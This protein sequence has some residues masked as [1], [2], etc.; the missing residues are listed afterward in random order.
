MEITHWHASFLNQTTGKV[1]HLLIVERTGPAFTDLICFAAG[2]EGAEPLSQGT[3]DNSRQKADQWGK[4]WVESEGFTRTTDVQ[5][6]FEPLEHAV[7]LAKRLGHV[8]IDDPLFNSTG[9]TPLSDWPGM[10]AENGGACKY[11]VTRRGIIA[12]SQPPSEYP[13]PR[14]TRPFFFVD[15]P[16]A[17]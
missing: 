10:K 16:P 14:S 5:P 7:E 1:R 17:N 6:P 9:S 15:T 3:L 8:A 2:K 12:A 13:D 4:A 11:A